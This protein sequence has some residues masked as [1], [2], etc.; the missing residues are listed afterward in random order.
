MLEAGYDHVF[1]ARP[2]KRLIQNEILDQLAEEMIKGKIKAG[3]R[4]KV[5]WQKNKLNLTQN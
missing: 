5:D 2:L 1:G 4:I 3:D